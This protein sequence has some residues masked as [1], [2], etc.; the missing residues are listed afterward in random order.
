MRQAAMTE[1]S[2]IK[3]NGKKVLGAKKR[4]QTTKIARI[5]VPKTTIHINLGEVNW[6]SQ[7]AANV[8]GRRRVEKPV[9]TRRRPITMAY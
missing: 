5:R 7:A 2:I 9:H 8:K 3:W 6:Y 4:S 1:R